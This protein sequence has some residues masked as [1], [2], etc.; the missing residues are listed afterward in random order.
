M[1]EVSRM[2]QK[3]ELVQKKKEIDQAM[4]RTPP[5]YEVHELSYDQLEKLME[6]VSKGLS[7]FSPI[8][9]ERTV[10]NDA[11]WT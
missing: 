4:S 2:Y 11:P 6:N 3:A 7:K 8:L 9:P 5:F 10:E 1:N